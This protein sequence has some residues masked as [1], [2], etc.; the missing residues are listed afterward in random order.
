MKKEKDVIFMAFDGE[1]QREGSFETVVEAWE[2]ENDSGSRWYFYPFRFVVVNET[3]VDTPDEF[4][5]LK[6]KR[7]STAAKLF[8]RCAAMPEAEDMDIYSF[9]YLVGDNHA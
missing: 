8:S 5:Y 6:R 3:I 1:Y 2:H 4:F 9:A 7:I